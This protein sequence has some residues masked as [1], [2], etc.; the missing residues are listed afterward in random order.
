MRQ[1]VNINAR[2]K[3]LVMEGAPPLHPTRQS[4]VATGSRRWILLPFLFVALAA[5]YAVA[6]PFFS[7][8]YLFKCMDLTTLFCGVIYGVFNTCPPWACF[9]PIAVTRRFTAKRIWI[10]GLRMRICRWHTPLRVWAS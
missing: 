9:K 6:Y 2:K 5:A 10:L 3:R 7:D 4:R 1:Y 8:T